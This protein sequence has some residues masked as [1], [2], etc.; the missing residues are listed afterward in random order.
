M[1]KERLFSR[2]Y[3]IFD[4]DAFFKFRSSPVTILAGICAII[5]FGASLGAAVFAPFDP[6]DKASIDLINSLLPPAWQDGGEPMFLLGTDD[7]GR[8]LLSAILYGTRTSVLVGLIS[9]SLAVIIGL[10]FGLIAGYFGGLADALIMRLVDVQMTFPAIMVAL[11]IDGV[12][13]SFLPRDLHDSLAIFVIILAM[14]QSIWPQVARTVRASTMVEKG[15]EYVQAAQVIG[16]APWI[17]MAR[18]VLPNVMGPVLVIATINLGVAILGE[19]T[20]SFLGVGIPASE[21][22]LGTLIRI[23]NNYVFSGERWIL[24][25]PGLTLAL[26]VLSINLLGDWLRDVLDPKLR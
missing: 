20:L 18:H 11:L 12:S 6:F 19:A 17:I 21:P 15:R 2:L 22:S 4:S 9:V 1:T 10:F 3:Q 26:L 7:Q 14:A 25:Y 8:D 16:R 13:R 23:G 24:I 5:L